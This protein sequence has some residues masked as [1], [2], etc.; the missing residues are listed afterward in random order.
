MIE[1]WVVR[2][3]YSSEIRTIETELCWCD[4]IHRPIDNKTSSMLILT[5]TV[6]AESLAALDSDNDGQDGQ[7]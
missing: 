5:S 4:V 3:L 6:Y 2:W 1:L 7:M